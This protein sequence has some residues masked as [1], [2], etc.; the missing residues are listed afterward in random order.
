MADVKARAAKAGRVQGPRFAVNGFVIVRETEAE[1]VSVLREIQGRADKEAV[2]AFGGAVKQAG[3][4]TGEKTGMWADSK[5]RTLYMYDCPR[6]VLCADDP[7]RQFEDL[8][9]YNDGFKTKL[10]GTPTQV[11]ERIL[12]LKSLGIGVVLCAFLHYEVDVAAFG[13]DVIPLVRELERQG[14][15]KDREFEIDRT[16]DVYRARG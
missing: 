1:A 2:D 9:Q 13:R 16:G 8:V 11:A 4:S 3:A 6:R 12:L 14:R 7:V 10:I 15:G 5:V